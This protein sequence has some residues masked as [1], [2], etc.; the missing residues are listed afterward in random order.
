M[1]EI[2]I[3]ETSGTLRVRSPYEPRFP[4]RARELGGRW[5]ASE[6]EWSFDPRDEARVRELLI[7][8]YGSDG[9]PTETCD[10]Q[11]R[12]RDGQTK[13]SSLFA[14]GRYLASAPG[15]DATTRY[16]AGVVLISGQ[17]ECGGSRAYPRLVARDAV[18][19]VRDVPVAA[20]EQQLGP[21][22]SSWTVKA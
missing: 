22:I 11:I 9:S 18:L 21:E 10:V 20:L 17:L 12:L 13:E 15:R 16:G 1:N 5:I 7:A 4:G 14:F 3:K 6:H 8:I 19:E 2:A